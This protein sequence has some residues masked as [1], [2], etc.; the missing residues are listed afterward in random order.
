MI[1]IEHSKLF[2]T[3][4]VGKDWGKCKITKIGHSKSFWTTLVGKGGKKCKMSKIEHSN[5]FWTNLVGKVQ[6]NQNWTFQII[7]NLFGRKRLEKSAK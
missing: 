5:L 1:K 2:W 4:L 7:L 3:T 6:N